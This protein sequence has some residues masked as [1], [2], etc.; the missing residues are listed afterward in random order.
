M[1]DFQTFEVERFASDSGETFPLIKLAY[2][3]LGRLN[4]RKDNAV[5][6]TVGFSGTDV[7]GEKAFVGRGRA[8][9]PDK[10]FVIIVNL[11]GSGRSSS[12][13]NAP[14][15]FDRGRFPKLTIADNVRL[16]EM[17]VTRH[18]GIETLRLVAGWSMGAAQAYQWGVSFGDKVER[19][20]AVAGAARTADYNKVFLNTLRLAIENDAAFDTGYYGRPPLAGLKAFAAIYAGW[21]LSEPFY[22]AELF[23]Q[24]G[25]K[26]YREFITSFWEPQFIRCDANNLLHQLW[27]WETADVSNHPRFQRDLPAALSSISAKTLI[28]P[29]DTDRYFPPAD[30]EFEVKHI[31]NGRL[32]TVNSVWGHYAPVTDESQRVIDGEIALLLAD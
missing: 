23:R 7:D 17:L 12:P 3:T 20:A 25:A 13:S 24:L 28:L 11:T 1:G 22:R 15:P 18:F 2:R 31:P 27:M 32:K 5:L 29:V 6:V 10:Y 19:I 9:D 26:D 8:I 30:A 4:E 16:Q 14:A 21:G